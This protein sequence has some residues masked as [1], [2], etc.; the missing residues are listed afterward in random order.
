MADSDSSYGDNWEVEE[1]TTLKASGFGGASK[2][3]SVSPPKAINIAVA[4]V[5]III[6][7]FKC[8]LAPSFSRGSGQEEAKKT[9]KP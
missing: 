7:L 5:S 2:K 6:V 1:N 4:K 9:T 3:R 8:E